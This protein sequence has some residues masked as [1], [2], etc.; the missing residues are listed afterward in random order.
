MRI[1]QPPATPGDSL[2]II[3]L[4]ELIELH[5][6]RRVEQ[7]QLQKKLLRDRG[8]FGKSQDRWK[9]VRKIKVEVSERLHKL[10]DGRGLRIGQINLVV[11]L[12]T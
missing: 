7:P 1:S 12:F 4:T 5:L 9:Q 11:H 6:D 3:S 2:Q 10:L 8:R